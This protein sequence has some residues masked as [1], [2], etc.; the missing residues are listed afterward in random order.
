MILNKDKVILEFN[1]KPFGSKQWFSGD[2]MLC[3]NCQT[4]SK[5]GVYF[6]EN[7]GIVHCF[8]DNFST[9]LHKY[10]K[11]IG[12]EN[13]ISFTRS[14][15]LRNELLPLINTKAP[16]DIKQSKISLPFGYKRIYFDEYLDERNFTPNE[17]NKFNVGICTERRLKDYI[18]FLVKNRED[19]CIGYVARSKNSKEWHKQNLKDY[20]AGKCSLRLRY[21]NSP[22]TDFSKILLGENEITPN[23]KVA[24]LVEGIFDK[25]NVDFQFELDK[26]EKIK[27]LCTWGNSLTPEQQQILIN[28]GIEDIVFFWDALTNTSSKKTSMKISKHFKNVKICEFKDESVDAGEA[29]K[30]YLE[31]VLNNSKDYFDFYVNRL[32]EL[33][34][35]V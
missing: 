17:Y 15:S 21:E 12:K 9:S 16:L 3:P 13:L 14:T 19:E 27:C 25:K 7:G 23:T 35:K 34:L 11:I 28:Y 2:S 32:D 22:N 29:S 24:W 20:K 10:L 31:N 4:S 30:Q 8:K 18:I 1:L 5:F 26:Q 6:T 33:K